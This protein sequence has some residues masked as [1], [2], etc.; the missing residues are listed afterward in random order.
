MAQTNNIQQTGIFIQR[1]YLDE[2]TCDSLLTQIQAYRQS[3]TVPTVFRKVKGRSLNYQVI[4]GIAISEH[5]SDLVQVYERINEFVNEIYG[6]P[7]YPLES[8]KVRLNVNITPVGGEYRW[9]YDRNRLTAILYLNEVEG[10]ETD[11]YP[12]FRINAKNPTLQRYF[13]NVL[14]QTWVRNTF[15]QLR[16]V[17][18]E[19]GTLVLMLG[20]QSLHSVRPVLGNIDRIN[21]ISSFDDLGKSFNV[22]PLLD[23]YLYQEKVELKSD[24]NYADAQK[25]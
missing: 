19:K 7:L 9:H 23:N 5:L 2:K 17:R 13:D 24:P 22:S 3:N 18:P 21:V 16:T 6:K 4:D 14:M 1:N 20:N 11:I 12:N 15:A 10:G 8:E 25:N